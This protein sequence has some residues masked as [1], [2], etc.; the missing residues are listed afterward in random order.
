MDSV[1]VTGGTGSMGQTLVRRLL[2]EH[3]QVTVFSRD[4]FKQFEMQSAIKD[5]RVKYVLGDIRD[6]AS[7]RAAMRDVHTVIHAAALKQVPSC[8]L[9]PEQA[10]FTNCIGMSNVV[11]AAQDLGTIKTVVTIS[12]DKACKPTTAMGMSKALQEKIFIA[13][14]LGCSTR[15]VGVRYGNVLES[16]GSV[17]PLFKKQIAE[18]G[19][20]T[21]TSST[22]TRF[23]LSLEQ[24]ADIVF[25]AILSGRA[26]DI[27][28]PKAP[29]ARVGTIAEVLIGETG[30]QIERIGV[31]PGEKYHE[32][33]VSREEAAHTVVNGEYY[34]IVPQLAG[35]V[36]SE[37]DP[38]PLSTT[39]Y[40]SS[41]NVMGFNDTRALLQQHGVIA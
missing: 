34:V 1:L 16:R 21:I 3:N 11:R 40:C 13:A 9:W 15:F 6:Y 19:P 20:V 7:V 28:V 10:V 18:G 37:K 23:L 27:F 39:E 31:R 4:E 35:L 22:M 41:R 36:H 5:S 33:M 32:V 12:T 30:V 8:E 17:I 38:H 14:N 26:G 25:D 29:S 2:Q 24:A